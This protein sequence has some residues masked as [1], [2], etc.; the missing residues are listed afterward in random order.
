MKIIQVKETAERLNT[1]ARE[2]LK[3]KL[4]ADIKMD[5]MICQLE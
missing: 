1:L 2:Q 5:I 4:L 3:L